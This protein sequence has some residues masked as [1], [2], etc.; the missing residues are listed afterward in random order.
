M[1]E[2]QV[3]FHTPDHP[4]DAVHL[5]VDIQESLEENGVRWV[6]VIEVTEVD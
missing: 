3:L 4:Y 6:E 5:L 2:Y 1:A